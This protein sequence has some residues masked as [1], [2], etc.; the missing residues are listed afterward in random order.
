MSTL[1]NYITRMPT[2]STQEHRKRKGKKKQVFTSQECSDKM[3]EHHQ[4]NL[5]LSR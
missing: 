3:V 2:E 4:L 5:S 1:I